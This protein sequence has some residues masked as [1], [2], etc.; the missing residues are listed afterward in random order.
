MI[1]FKSEQSRQALAAWYPRFRQRI[2]GALEERDVPTRFGATH[3][4]LAGPAEAPPLVVVHGAFASSAHALSELA[5]L[6]RTHRLIAP[7]VLG[8]SPMSADARLPLDKDSC[9]GWL[10]DVLDGVGV[11]RAALFGVSWGGFVALRAAAAAPQRFERL[12]LMVPAGFVGSPPLPA[13]WSIGLPMLGWRLLRREASLRAF[14]SALF[15]VHDEDWMRW[16]GDAVH[17][18]KTNFSAPPLARPED[19]AGWRGPVLV[20]GASD[21]LSFPGAALLARVRELFP[22]AETEWLEDCKHAPPFEDA[23]RERICERIGRFLGEAG[24]A[25]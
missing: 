2:P 16:L 13:L 15:T 10:C 18:F 14:A 7:D 25:A 9:G 5:P 8:Q 4:L 17:H 3:V 12:V 20:F 11:P 6:A 22:G 24:R 23:F 19:V 21:D 1:V